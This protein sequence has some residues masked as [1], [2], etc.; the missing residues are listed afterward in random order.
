[1]SKL[2]FIAYSYSHRV[3]SSKSFESSKVRITWRIMTIIKTHLMRPCWFQHLHVFDVL[4]MFRCEYEVGYVVWECVCFECLNPCV[5]MG[6]VCAPCSRRDS[7]PAYKLA[8]GRLVAG[9]ANMR[10]LCIVMYKRM[11]GIAPAQV[12][13]TQFMRSHTRHRWVLF[14]CLGLDLHIIL[15]GMSA[16]IEVMYANNLIFSLIEF[17]YKLSEWIK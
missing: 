16:I 2:C 1:M 3:R 6:I 11:T 8:L 4:H 14:S 17:H 10:R 7:N 12:L 15:W 9:C 5:Q 13:S